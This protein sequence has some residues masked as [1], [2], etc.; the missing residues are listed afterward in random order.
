MGP[1]LYTR[2]VETLYL[3]L[4]VHKRLRTNEIFYFK[5]GLIYFEFVFH[6]FKFDHLI[7]TWPHMQ[8]NSIISLYEGTIPRRRLHL[9]TSHYQNWQAE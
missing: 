3:S 5:Y 9:Q 6:H 1:V 7:M 8:I 2:H 4:N